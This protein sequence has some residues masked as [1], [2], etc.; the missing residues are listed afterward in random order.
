VIISVP[1]L[2]CPTVR[3]VQLAML[4]Q[5]NTEKRLTLDHVLDVD[6]RIVMIITVSVVIGVEKNVVIGDDRGGR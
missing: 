1:E 3:S 5:V 2:T 4:R 6:V